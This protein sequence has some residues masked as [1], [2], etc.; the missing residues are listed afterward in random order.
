MFLLNWGGWESINI[1]R[2]SP[3]NPLHTL[4]V[5]RSLKKFNPII[6]AKLMRFS[7]AHKRGHSRIIGDMPI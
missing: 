7:Y 6:W 3:K 1:K 5:E 2:K 4:L